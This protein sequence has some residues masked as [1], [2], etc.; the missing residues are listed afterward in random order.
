MPYF[1]LQSQVFHPFLFSL[2]LY[3]AVLIVLAETQLIDIDHTEMFATISFQV[4]GAYRFI[5]RCMTPANNK[6][7]GMSSVMEMSSTLFMDREI[8]TYT[9]CT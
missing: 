5:V 3:A 4:K 9:A 1:H 6:V 2:P 7:E 8:S